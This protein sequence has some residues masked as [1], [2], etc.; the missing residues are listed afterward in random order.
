MIIKGGQLLAGS[1]TR[2]AII[3]A[4]QTVGSID[5]GTGT[6]NF[7]G[8]ALAKAAVYTPPARIVTA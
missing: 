5:Y 7:T 2:G 3:A 8:S 6:V 4:D 1:S